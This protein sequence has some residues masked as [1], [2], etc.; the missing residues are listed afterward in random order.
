MVADDH[1]S[2]QTRPNRH[3]RRVDPTAAAAVGIELATGAPVSAHVEVLADGAQPA[4]TIAPVAS[5]LVVA[6]VVA[7]WPGARG[8]NA[9]LAFLWSV[10]GPCGHNVDSAPAGHPDGGTGRPL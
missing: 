9:L 8:V 3:G 5:V 6:T 10:A 1:S 7:G 2:V 4:A